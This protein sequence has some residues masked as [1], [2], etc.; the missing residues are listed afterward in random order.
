[1][2]KLNI[3]KPTYKTIAM[4]ALASLFFCGVT[5]QSVMAETKVADSKATAKDA[6]APVDLDFKKLDVNGDN[7]ISL[8]EAVKDKALATSFDVTDANKDG[9]ITADEYASYKAGKSMDSAGAPPNAS[10]SSTT[11]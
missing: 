2:L 10:T 7:K 5:A 6:G 1:M 4:T 11:P 8:K 9:S 3:S